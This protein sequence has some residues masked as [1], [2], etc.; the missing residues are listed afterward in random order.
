M[1]LVLVAAGLFLYLRLGAELDD[2]IDRNLEARAGVFSE[3]GEDTVAQVLDPCAGAVLQSSEEAGDAPLLTPAQTRE[4]LD[5]EVTADREIDDDQLPPARDRGGRQRGR[6][7]RVARRPRR[8]G[9]QPRR[10]AADRRPDPPAPD[11]R[12]RLRRDRR[13]AAPGRAHARP[14]RRDRGDRPRR[15]PAGAAGRRR[16]RPAGRDAQRHAR[17]HRGGVHARADVRGRR[18]PRAAHAAGDPQDRARAGA[19]P[20]AHERGARPRRCRA[21]PR[22]PTASS[23]S[24]RTCW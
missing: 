10:A 22:R 2:G 1:A 16:D 19:E 8:G 17:P 12:H 21:P 13:R 7:R 3:R 20:R 9:L 18:Q 6:G 4:A 14:R 23:R 24:P 15:P 11:R 5:D